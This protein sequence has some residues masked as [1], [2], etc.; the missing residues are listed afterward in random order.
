MMLALP[1]PPGVLAWQS[2][3]GA[4]G[5]LPTVSSFASTC[6]GPEIVLA[7]S[8]TDLWCRRSTPAR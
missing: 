6:T 5:V 4:C 3:N 8:S 2:I 1:A 7:A